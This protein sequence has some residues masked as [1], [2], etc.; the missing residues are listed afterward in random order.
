MTTILYMTLASIHGEFDRCQYILNRVRP[1][2]RRLTPFSSL[3]RF[4]QHPPPLGQ[5][6]GQA[7]KCY[8]AENNIL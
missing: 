1:R 4:Q 7:G 3:R 2:K 5:D 8:R 6:R